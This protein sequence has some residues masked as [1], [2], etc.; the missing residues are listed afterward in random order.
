MAINVKDDLLTVAGNQAAALGIFFEHCQSMII[1]REYSLAV[2]FLLKNLRLIHLLTTARA[3]GM[4]PAQTSAA[5]LTDQL[6][7]GL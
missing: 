4:F 7:S 3:K 1:K 6:Q 5:F 2:A